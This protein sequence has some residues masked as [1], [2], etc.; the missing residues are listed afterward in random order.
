MEDMSHT[1]LSD[2]PVVTRPGLGGSLL[3]MLYMKRLPGG[4]GSYT[5]T[6]LS[7]YT[8]VNDEALWICL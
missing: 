5:E 8:R 2:S 6:V 7:S 1:Q 3:L 4:T